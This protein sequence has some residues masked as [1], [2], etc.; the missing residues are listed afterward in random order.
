M[1]VY[2][3]TF[4]AMF[5]LPVTLVLVAI[6]LFSIWT[7]ATVKQRHDLRVAEL[8][9]DLSGIVR[10]AD[11]DAQMYGIHHQ[12]D[13]LL[14]KAQLHKLDEAQLYQSHVE[15]VDRLSAMR[16][17]LDLIRKSVRGQKLQVTELA[18][19]EA[20]F[21]RYRSDIIM[22]TDAIAVDPGQAKSYLK[23]ATGEYLAI[24]EHSQKI[25]G[26]LADHAVQNGKRFN[27]RLEDF[28]GKALAASM[29]F[30]AAAA[31]SWFFA[32]RRLTRHMTLIS[33]GLD[34][35]AGGKE[36]QHWDA[37]A[38]LAHSPTQ[39]PIQRMANA[40]L[41]FVE[42]VD[43]RKRSLEEHRHGEAQLRALTETLEQRIR[44]EQCLYRVSS[45][46]EDVTPPFEEQMR[47]VAALV[48]S[49]LRFPD[50]AEARLTHGAASFK[51]AGFAPTPWTLCAR[52]DTDDGDSFELTV[53]YREEH[54]AADEGPFLVEERRLLENILHRLAEA[55]NR[56]RAA[57]L[58]S[59]RD[60]LIATM[61]EQSTESILLIDVETLGFVDFNN[62]AHAG[63]G[64]T[65]EEFALLTVSD[66]EGN[67]TV[68]ELHALKEEL[69]ERD[70][71]VF[72]TRHRRKDG[73]LR[74]VS[75][76]LRLI[77]FKGQS[78]ISSVWRDI[79]E[80]LVREKELENYRRHLEVM[81]DISTAELQGAN[82]EQRA[83]FEA[84]DVGILL[85]RDRIIGRHNAK[86]EEIFGYQ[87]RELHGQSTKMLYP[88]EEAFLAMGTRIYERLVGGHTER[89]EI[90]LRRKDGTLFWAR[91]ST[92]PLDKQDL[93]KGIVILVEDI[94]REREATEELR[95]AKEQAE[96]EAHA[97]EELL[98]AMRL[99]AAQ[100]EEQAAEMEMQAIT[101]AERT[102]QL[103]ELN[104]EQRAI[105][106]AATTGIVLVQDRTIMSCNRKLEEIFGYQPE[107]LLNLTTRCW[108]PDDD[109]FLR[110][111]S[112]IA[113]CLAHSGIFHREEVP[114]L[115]KDGNTFWARVS[116]QCLRENDPSGGQVSIIE[117]VTERR[118]ARQEVIE[119]REMLRLILNSTAEA[120]Y[121]TDPDG[122]CT[123]CNRA[124]V[125]LLGYHDEEELIGRNMH[126]MI[127]HRD[128]DGSLIDLHECRIFQG[129]Q[130]GEG[131]H[132][133]D[134]VLWRKDGSSFPAE[135]WSY[136][137]YRDGRVVGA[138]VTFLDI[139]ERKKTQQELVVA[140][141]A[142]EAASQTKSDFLANMSHEIR[143][144]MNAII[145]M[146]HLVM[147]TSLTPQQ[148]DYLSKIQA[149]GE[150]L[151]GIINDI[152]D[153]SKIEAGKLTI[154]EAEFDLERVM[155]TL[156]TFL[157][158]KVQ[159]KGLEL[160]FDVAPEVPRHLVGDSLRLGQVLLNYGSN[161]VK[162]TEAGEINV[163]VGVVERSRNTVLLQFS[164]TDTGIGLD[165]QQQGRLFQSFQQG[166]MSTTRKYGG[167]GLGLAI[168]RH[169]ARLM[170]GE[171]GVES[172]K[173]VGS[174]FWCTV[175]VG[176]SR[177]N[178]KPRVTPIALYGCR[179][180]VVDDN[181]HARGVL[182]A[183]LQRTGLRSTPAPSGTEALS[184][185]KRGDEEGDPFSIV[186]LDWQMQG[187]SGA[188]T[189]R[190]I[191]EL[192][193]FSHPHL[194][195][196]T[197]FGREG[198]LGL[199]PAGSDAIILAK[200]AS[201]SLLLDAAMT[202]MAQTGGTEKTF[203][204]TDA[205]PLK[206]QRITG[207]VLL[208]E[209]NEINRQVA[210][211]LL[212]DTGLSVDLAN[213]GQEALRKVA[214]NSYDLVLMDMQMPV[215]DGLEATAR[216]RSNPAKDRLPIVAMTANALP[217]DRAACLAAGMNDY[218]TK[219][220]DPAIL[221]ATVLKWVGLS[222]GERSSKASHAQ[223]A[224]LLPDAVKG[225]DLELGLKRIGGE[226]R[227][228]LSLL[229]K[230]RTSQR[231]TDRQLRE[232]LGRGDRET[233]ARIVHT[234]K[235]VAG[236]IGAEALQTSAVELEQ[237]LQTRGMDLEPELGRFSQLL[238]G[239][240]HE[241]RKKLPSTPVQDL[242]P[243]AP[244]V[245]EEVCREFARLL[246]DDDAAATEHFTTHALLLR[247][248]F[249]QQ[250][251]R[252]E[253]AIRTYDFE[254]ALAALA[255][256]QGE[257]EGDA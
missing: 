14:E 48:P 108:Y 202:V 78:L 132:A 232:A 29:I 43:Q 109:S 7:L 80:Q 198:D 82:S 54:Q 58:V 69:S 216:I 178:E 3:P 148:L 114:F 10:A 193:L 207:R 113:D 98:Q 121:G 163:R 52:L 201:P 24:T 38:D 36:L 45:L 81:I 141:E 18:Q 100:L 57:E 27:E 53:A 153:F 120:I 212:M 104:L 171:V 219:P 205:A 233:A 83:I 119:G 221:R 157:G 138:V 146:S 105:F 59:E 125:E 185:L 92:Q 217:S 189:A 66:I 222:E 90:P 44:E 122:I 142:A 15:V 67:F 229:E 30:M 161:A 243:A 41:A 162:F 56:R 218:I 101:L 118:L 134:E 140:K 195:I 239:L 213:N 183:M 154:E 47:Q 50:C 155:G 99:Q 72:Q 93:G 192:D 169:L 206:E 211:E 55:A 223:G 203:P 136:P 167:T 147:K 6:S 245:L 126:D 88:D 123:F 152:L 209:D 172:E 242:P 165:K 65:R 249:P 227:A 208:V 135:Y 150:H 49:G 225:I 46:T 79:T 23:L 68:D 181:E 110:F 196:L 129:Y 103:E 238:A 247:S 127:H 2:R 25:V 175:R 182:H 149:S 234:M 96:R 252:I 254:A 124:C 139:T 145:G 63:L 156:A 19:L 144:P 74:D 131:T 244:G 20:D 75:M 64:Y 173:G 241:L 191:R 158:D 220:F 77:T 130:N 94:T 128:A 95:R 188:E 9:G 199:M 176:V 194:I 170:G 186:F 37:V 257:Q 164:V 180:L 85:V 235:S 115:R 97:K 35:L 133:D 91:L 62:A 1:R 255:E 179:V 231:H 251:A 51:T 174:T 143:T 4:F 42:A 256:A 84:A 86:V 26:L 31:L 248:A 215:M 112:E 117:D 166:D 253:G 12:L 159:A 60:K 137:Q 151:L 111:G 240:L 34:D 32:T 11:F 76:T 70:V 160:I 71:T 5:F 21:V 33:T 177:R 200:P 190:L 73:V 89:D 106:D 40:V 226:E 230:F 102:A 236:N 17:K 228:Y 87:G 237:A 246:S 168:S 214:Q 250:F 204:A 184:L 28:S 8:A 107:E 210:L 116:V 13:T 187:M 22:A 39:G 224:T 197:P 61:F 16:S